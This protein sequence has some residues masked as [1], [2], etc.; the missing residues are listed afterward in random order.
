MGGLTRFLLGGAVGAILGF[1]ISEK[2]AGRRRGPVRTPEPLQEVQ[3][4]GPREEG[5]P[6]VAPGGS[7]AEPSVA[8]PVVGIE[9]EAELASAARRV[10]ETEPVLSPGVEGEGEPAPA[11]GSEGEAG[12]E[13]E[14]ESEAET[15]SRPEPHVESEEEVLLT[16]EV[17]EEPL[18]GTGWEPSG[19]RLAEAEDLEEMLILDPAVLFAA[20]PPEAKPAPP[21]GE[22]PSQAAEL[23][24]LRT[25]IEETRRRIQ[26]EL[27]RPFAAPETEESV[28]QREPMAAPGGK[29]V[30]GE[31]LAVPPADEGVTE[32]VA[33]T[34]GITRAPDERLEMEYEAVRRRIEATRSRLKAKAFDAMMAGESALL[35]R[36]TQQGLAER[37]APAA[38]DAEVGQSIDSALREEEA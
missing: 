20:S 5:E 26:R 8:E 4:R 28:D 35:R 10:S 33:A 11:V 19:A 25:R 7:M 3:R 17:L 24:D 37:P 1:L 30:T 18:P 22:S 36:E 9:A 13:Q 31:A 23:D 38:L 29:P 32:R 2:R 12:R 15:K 34:E 16:P 21:G 6:G 14:V 27:E